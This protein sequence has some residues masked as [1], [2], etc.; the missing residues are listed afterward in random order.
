MT[1]LRFGRFV[2]SDLA[3]FAGTSYFHVMKPLEGSKLRSASPHQLLKACDALG[4][5]PVG[6]GCGL[7]LLSQPCA[8]TALALGV[9]HRAL[10]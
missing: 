9:A 5:L 8:T 6:A 7:G 2:G 10:A 4:D 3:H 1:S